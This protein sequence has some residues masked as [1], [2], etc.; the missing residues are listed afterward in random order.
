MKK[1]LTAW[2]WSL[3]VIVRSPLVLLA[4]SALVA[5]G[6][7]GAYRWLY[8]P[9]ESAV[10]LM[11]VG[12][13][14]AFVQFFVLVGFFAVTASAAN[15]AAAGGADSLQLRKLV[16][17]SRSDWLRAAAF[18]ILALLVA[19]GIRFLFSLINSYSLEVASFL[20]FRSEKPVAPETIESVF[21]WVEN[22]V[23][24]VILGF[25][26]S[27]LLALVRQGWRETLRGVPRLLANSCWRTPFL[28]SLISILIFGGLAYLLA[29]WHPQAPTG[30]LDYAQAILRNGLALLLAVAGW[31]FWM[32]ALA[33]RSQPS[34]SPSDSSTAN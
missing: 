9:M 31:L 18:V 24:V 23:W 33:S 26:L 12:L 29:T 14:W 21:G 28:T 5:A 7:Y 6:L 32:L 19:G 1:M 16:R 10:Y 22:L 20:T 13:L 2:K 11:V 25:L 4:L 34:G 27:F 8:F 15:N 3:R 30:F 17:F